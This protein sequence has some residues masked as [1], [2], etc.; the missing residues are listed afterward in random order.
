MK[1]KRKLFFM[2]FALSTI[3]GQAQLHFRLEGNIGIPDFTGQFIIHDIVGEQVIDSV[4]VVNGELVP[5]EGE[6]P[7]MVQCIMQGT[8]DGAS[9]D[10]KGVSLAY[11]FLTEGTTRIDGSEKG[12]LQTSGTAICEELNSYKKA[13]KEIVEKY[14]DGQTDK[15]YAEMGELCQQHLSRHTTDV[16]GLYLLIQD[17]SYVLKP[18]VW[19]DLC[20]KL[21]AGLSERNHANKTLMEHVTR[22]KTSMTARAKTDVGC[23]FVDFAVEYE[24]K[25]T[26]LS[27][28]VGKGKYVL[29]DFW[30]SW[31]APCRAELPNI[32]AAYNTYKDSGL[33]VL[34]IAAWDKPEATL[35][36]IDEEKIPYPQII[37]SQKIATDVYGISGIPEIILFGPDGTIVARGLRDKAI[38]AKMAE[39][40]GKK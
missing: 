9:E 30:A 5:I 22:T 37:N 11:L 8:K 29:A 1:M 33:V 21:E 17:G 3:V 38:G 15:L 14:K 32:I 26:R 36:A 19:I 20:N 10:D 40:F 31:C 34:G 12:M 2:A 35:K 16:Y 6:I 23:K 39:I 18:A 27:D 13:E 7:E 28:Y 24:G 4:R 25:T